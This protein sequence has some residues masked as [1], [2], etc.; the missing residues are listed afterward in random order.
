MSEAAGTPSGRRLGVRLAALALLACAFVGLWQANALERWNFDGP[1]PGLFPTLVGVVF[2]V[3]ALVVVIFPGPAAG[4]E[5]ADTE[6]VPTQERAPVQRRFAIY[7][8]GLLVMALGTAYLGFA[9]TSLLLSVL[10]VA[11][12]E[13]RSWRAAIVYGLVCAL[14]GLVVFG[15]LLRVDL[16]GGPIERA[17]F[18]LVR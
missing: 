12:A 3:L 8:L 2:A 14:L 1:G 4:G 15:W 7:S 6:E 11:V 5:A 17:F 18:S 9:L 16:P 13:G 10:I